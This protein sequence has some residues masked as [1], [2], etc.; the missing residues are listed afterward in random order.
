ML[1]HCYD[2]AMPLREGAESQSDRIE[3]RLHGCQS[4]HRIIVITALIPILGIIILGKLKRII[5]R[6]ALRKS[7]YHGTK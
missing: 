5:S 4:Q 2:L 3:V 7:I 6:R 1:G